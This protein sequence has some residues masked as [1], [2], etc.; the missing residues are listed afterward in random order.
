LCARFLV[1]VLLVQ[2]LL[3]AVFSA[4]DAS[5]FVSLLCGLFGVWALYKTWA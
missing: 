1:L 4:G 3:G 2:A 5:I